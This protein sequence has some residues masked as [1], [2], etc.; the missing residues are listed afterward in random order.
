L[1]VRFKS[2]VSKEIDMQRESR[3][4]EQPAEPRKDVK[5]RQRRFQIVKLEERIAPGRGGH[6]R[7]SDT[8]CNGCRGGS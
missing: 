7:H 5:E 8:N 4:E 6:N 3:K 1:E 2:H